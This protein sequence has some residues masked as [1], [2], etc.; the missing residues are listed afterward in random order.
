MIERNPLLRSAIFL[1]VEAE[2]ARERARRAIA[3]V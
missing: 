1:E 3:T 2:F